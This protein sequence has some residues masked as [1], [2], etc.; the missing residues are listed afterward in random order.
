MWRNEWPCILRHLAP[1][2]KGVEAVAV[3]STFIWY[4]LV[5]GLMDAGDKVKPVNTTAVKM[6]DGL[7][8]SH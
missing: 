1:H 2:E 5:D 4:W 8:Y 6:Y 3:E 7:K